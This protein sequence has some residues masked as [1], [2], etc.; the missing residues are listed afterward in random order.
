M[1]EMLEGR[2]LF[3]AVTPADVA[4]SPEPKSELPAVQQDLSTAKVSMQDFH[5]TKKENTT[6]LSLNFS[7]VKFQDFHFTQ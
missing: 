6:S 4:P 3:A 1:F 5:F 7:K 2:S